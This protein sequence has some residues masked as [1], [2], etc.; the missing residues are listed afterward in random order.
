MTREL[1]VRFSEGEG[2]RFPFATRLIPLTDRHVRAIL[3]EWIRHY[4]RGRPTQQSWAW[5]S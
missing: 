3:R 5:L 1:H 4:N 2:V